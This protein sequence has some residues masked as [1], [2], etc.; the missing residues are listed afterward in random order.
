DADFIAKVDLYFGSGMQILGSGLA[1]LAITRFLTKFEFLQQVFGRVSRVW[2]NHF[3]LW[4][5]T[6]VPI[7]IF[8]VLAMYL[9]SQFLS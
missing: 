2:H 1:V 5:L 7:T 6:A 4:I 9:W 8:I 3:Y